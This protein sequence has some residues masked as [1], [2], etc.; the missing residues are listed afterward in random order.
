MDLS[1]EV[2]LD[3]VMNRQKAAFSQLVKNHLNTV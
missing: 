2:F 1:V 3:S